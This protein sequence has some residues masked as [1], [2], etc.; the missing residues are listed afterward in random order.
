MN[1]GRKAVAAAT[2]L[3]GASRIFIHKAGAL[4][5]ALTP[6]KLPVYATMYMKKQGLIWN[7]GSFPEISC[8]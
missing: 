2:A 6:W 1:H 3:K 4:T 5:G 8:T 7:S